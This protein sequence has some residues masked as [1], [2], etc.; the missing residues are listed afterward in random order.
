MRKLVS[1]FLVMAILCCMLYLTASA[2]DT[3][4]IPEL[5]EAPITEAPTEAPATEPSEYVQET[6][7]PATEPISADYEFDD[8]DEDITVAE[9]TK[10]P[11]KKVDSDDSNEQ[12]N[13][14]ETEE[15][16]YSKTTVSIPSTTKP[17][18]VA[19][20]ITDFGKQFTVQKWIA[21]AIMLLSAGALIFINVRH[22]KLKKKVKQRKMN[23]NSNDISSS[24]ANRRK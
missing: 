2:L 21:F 11:T 23:K 9:Q 20:K 17:T 6:D 15:Q 3:S 16:A 14:V 13:Q 12:E 24:S 10:K 5:T 19:K 8:D 4:N 7:A 18:T 22:F 1:S